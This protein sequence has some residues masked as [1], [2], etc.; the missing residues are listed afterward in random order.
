[1]S[2][3]SRHKP[4]PAQSTH[5]KPMQ[6]VRTESELRDTI[7]T[8]RQAGE[9]IAFVPTMGNLHAG[10]LSLVTEARQQAPRCVVSIFVNPMQFNDP[11]DLQRYPRTFAADKAQLLAAGVDMLFVPEVETVYPDGMA[12][13]TQVVVPGLSQRLEGEHR[14]GHFT[15]VTTVVSKLFNLVQPDIA[16]FGKKDY[17]Q[18]LLIRQ[19]T[20]DLNFPIQIV[21][22]ETRR[23]AS[24]LA[25]SSRNGLMDDKSRDNARKIHEVLQL[26]AESIKSDPRSLAQAQQQAER[27][28]ED[29]GFK[30]EY[31]AICQQ[32]ALKSAEIGDKALVILVA[33]QYA[34]VRLIDNIELSL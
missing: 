23:E 11:D 4:S 18:L 13:A 12:L 10:H 5:F 14:P 16:V 9:R 7:A 33:V 17:Q 6:I 32:H 24:G 28:L 20:R 34:G 8:W 26:C 30:V 25:M 2:A 27:A 1:M 3:R 22:A 21:A 29:A 15:G 31:V 19:M